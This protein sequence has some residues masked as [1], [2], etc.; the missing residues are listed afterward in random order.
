[1]IWLQ[2]LQLSGKLP[3]F[4]LVAGPCF[5]RLGISGLDCCDYNPMSL[6]VTSVAL[7]HLSHGTFWSPSPQC[8]QLR[9]SWSSPTTTYLGTH[10]CKF[11][12]PRGPQS[13]HLAYPLQFDSFT[14]MLWYSEL[15]TH[16][17]FFGHLTHFSPRQHSYPKH[18]ALPS[19][20]YPHLHRITL[21]AL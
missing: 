20:I 6:H 11:W 12:C 5:G 14:R 4:H 18:C 21:N 9:S 3:P 19:H 10:M 1:M 8:A 17:L 15:P 16:A 13:L 2:G 7:H